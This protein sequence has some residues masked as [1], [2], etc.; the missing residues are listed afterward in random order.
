MLKAFSWQ[1]FLL[2]A[3]ILSLLWWLGIYLCFFW[4]KG[5]GIAGSGAASALP[6]SWENQVDDLDNGLMG[7]PVLEHGV[8]VVEAEDFSFGGSEMEDAGDSAKLE[9]LG[10]LADVQQEIKEVCRILAAEDG[11]KEDFFVLFE[12]VKGKY[13]GIALSPS[14][15]ALNGFI[16]EQVP[17]AL[18][19]QELEDLWL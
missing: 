3:T 12:M 5:G 6:H 2:A 15:A 1:D 7:K 14:L 17:F 11:T 10:D 16:R 9:Q 13:P 19:S 4:K 8:S 18:S